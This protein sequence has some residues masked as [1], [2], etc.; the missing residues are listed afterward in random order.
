MAGRGRIRDH[1][2]SSPIP[3][4]RANPHDGGMR[5]RRLLVSVLAAV[6][7]LTGVGVVPL[8]VRV[9]HERRYCTST[10]RSGH[11]ARR[12]MIEF[13]RAGGPA[14]YGI[15]ATGGAWSTRD[16][17]LRHCLARQQEQRTG[18][19]GLWSEDARD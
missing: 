6:V 16:E 1:S 7:V 15:V 13:N 11:D 9:V 12:Q 18:F 19:L 2:G 10:W 5:H 3:A 4:E 17:Y 8:A 14:P